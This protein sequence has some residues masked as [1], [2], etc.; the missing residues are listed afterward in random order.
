MA[1]ASIV[2]II[3]ALC[4][5]ITTYRFKERPEY[6]VVDKPL[7]LKDA[8]KYTFKSKA[9]LIVAAANFMSIFFQQI[10][11]SYMVYLAKHVMKMSTTIM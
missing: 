8:I 7:G 6:T 9:F 3:G 2:G 4:I 10:L 1:I 5:V 11:L